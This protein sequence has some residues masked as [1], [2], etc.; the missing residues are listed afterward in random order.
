MKIRAGDG[1]EELGHA[2]MLSTPIFYCANPGDKIT[3]KNKKYK[4]N[5]ATY[6]PEIESKWIYT[7]DY[8]PDQSWT[9][10]NNDLSGDSYRQDEHIFD[11]QLYFRICLRKINGEK[12]DGSENINEILEFNTNPIPKKPKEWI[13]TEVKRITS[14]ISGLSNK[15]NKKFIVLSDTHYNIN[16][17]WDDTYFAINQL[18]QQIKP[19]GIIHLGDIT[20]G[21]VTGD[22]TKH[23]AKI[24]LN[25]LKNCGTPVHIVPGNHD[26][27]YFRSNPE[28]FSY[29]QQKNI[30]F[31]DNDPR[32][33]IDLPSL[34]M[35]FLDSYDY[36]EEL[37]YGYSKECI[38]WLEEVLETT[39]DNK[40]VFIFSHL[41]PVARLQ[42]W[43]K[44]I[45]GESEIKMLLK[46]HKEKL[47]G[48]INGHNHAD[49]LDNDEGYPIISIANSKCEAFTEHKTEGFITPERSLNTVTQEAFDIMIINPEKETV[50]FIRFGAGKDRVI[51]NRKAEWL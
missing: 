2:E 6:R 18:C 5:I 4:F 50:K 46:T 49:R 21:M 47:L 32:H 12:F 17:T 31:N 16:G 23:Y 29:E 41:P 37:R 24:I 28:P 33:C 8:A 15:K 38:K 13:I 19:D 14:K 9:V 22:A 10:Y 44:A 7:Y 45:R 26:S 48:W 3:L 30:Y 36:I 1:C 39:P 42:F 25:D 34:R 20:D 27:N 35:I 40:K 43:T 11:D 51:K